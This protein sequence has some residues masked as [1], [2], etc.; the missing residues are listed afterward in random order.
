MT[1]ITYTIRNLYIRSNLLCVDP[2]RKVCNEQKLRHD[3]YFEKKRRC[4]DCSSSFRL[5]NI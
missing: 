3:D 4:Q 1:D 5:A 2:K